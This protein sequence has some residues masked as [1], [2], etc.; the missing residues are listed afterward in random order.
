[1]SG[2]EHLIYLARN[3]AAMQA[4]HV[5]MCPLAHLVSQCICWLHDPGG[6]CITKE[7]ARVRLPGQPGG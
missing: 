2:Q 7:R 5:W 6:L 3:S 1:M 4:C